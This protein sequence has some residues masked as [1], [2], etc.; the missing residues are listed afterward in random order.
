MLCVQRASTMTRT[1]NRRVIVEIKVLFNEHPPQSSTSNTFF[2]IG[3]WNDDGTVMFH[4]KYQK[5]LYFFRRARIGGDRRPAVR[6][7]LYLQLAPDRGQ[8][9]N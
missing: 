9:S 6:P 7:N 8:Y 1:R 4:A 3:I 2:F 5:I